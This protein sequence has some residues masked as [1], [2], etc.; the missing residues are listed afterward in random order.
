MD[1]TDIRRY[2][3]TCPKCKAKVSAVEQIIEKLFDID[4]GEA[5]FDVDEYGGVQSIPIICYGCA[6][7]WKLDISGI[8]NT[9]R[10]QMKKV[11]VPNEKQKELI[12]ANKLQPDNWQVISENKAELEIRSRRSGRRRILEKNNKKNKEVT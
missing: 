1:K 12:I 8:R 3:W 5:F 6:S 10:N 9:G 11:G 2:Y 7:N 4:D